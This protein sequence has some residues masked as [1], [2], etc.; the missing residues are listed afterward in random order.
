MPSIGITG[1]IACGK[2]LVTKLLTEEMQVV[3]FNADQA[4]SHLLDYDPEV[5]KEIRMHFG[6]QSYDT[7]AKA[8][9][10]F[11][12]S[13]IIN[14]PNQKKILEDILHPR[15]RKQWYPQAMKALKN[16][17]TFFFAEIPLLYEKNL[18]PCFD[19]VIVVGASETT[20]INRLIHYRQLSK[21]T[22]LQFLNLQIPLKKKITQANYLLWNDGSQ[23][24]L[25]RQSLKIVSQLMS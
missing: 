20:Q 24:I 15:L 11:L 19:Y 9:R 5:S 18:S 21:N 12:R 7:S 8:N 16:P 2:S 22:A 1:G 10:I 17:S 23:E 25:K 4:V 3:P 14:N 6:T 13:L